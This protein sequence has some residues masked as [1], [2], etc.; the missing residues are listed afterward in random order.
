VKFGKGHKKVGG[1][2]KGQVQKRT[3]AWDQL[4]EFFTQAGAE[5]A[6][7]IMIKADDK[8]FMIYYDKLIEYFKPKLQRT[9]LT[10]DGEKI[11]PTAPPQIIIKL[12]NG[13]DSQ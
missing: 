13:K 3:R 12:D 5:R 8:E 10:T 11:I 7:D 1:I 4:G 9:D 2:K 6:K